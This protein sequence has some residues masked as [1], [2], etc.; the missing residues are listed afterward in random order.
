MEVA[1]VFIA[2]WLAVTAVVYL[3]NRKAVRYFIAIYWK[4]ENLVKYVHHFTE[5]L[6]FLPL[7][8]YLAIVVFLAFMPLLLFIPTITMDGRV[9]LQ[10]G[11]LYIF[12]DGAVGAFRE[13]LGG[14]SVE[15]AAAQTSGITPIIPG[16][17]LPWDQLPY[18]AIAIATA[19]VLHE[20]MHGYAAVRYGIPIKSLGVFSLLYIFSGAFVEP[21]E[22]NFKKAKTEAKVAV[23]SSGVAANVALA[24]LAMIVGALGAWLGLSGAVFGKE[25]YGVQQGDYV[26]EISGCGVSERVYNPDDLVTK[27]NVLSGL[28][29]LLGVDKPAACRPGDEITLVARRWFWSY[30]TVVDFAN[31]T[32]PPKL[33]RLFPDGSLYLGGV[34]EGDVVKEIS[35]CGVSREVRWSG[36]F[37]SVLMEL[38]NACR[39]GDVVEVVVERGGVP[40]KFN[41]S[42]VGDGRV[43]FGVGFGS[44]PLWGFHEG[45]ISRSEMYNTDFTRLIFWLIVINYGLALINILP[46]YPLDGGQLLSTLARR[47]FGEK[48]GAKLTT[49]VSLVFVAILIFQLTLGVL[50]EQYR[51]LQLI[52]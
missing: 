27:I 43:Y 30:E 18:I 3:V 38:R 29:P 14:A 2:S 15:K 13:L 4:S 45:A 44:L 40:L 17:T 26:I 6:S 11:F 10:A 52:R 9:V 35:G 34:R 20:L 16:V 5:K 32:T 31:F 37:V 42:L 48:V 24:I 28:G 49:T 21:D 36:E 8:L 50:G 46:I 1:L 51:I 41:V 12:L 47:L 23:L 19:V 22:E 33:L 7:R 39:V 25:A